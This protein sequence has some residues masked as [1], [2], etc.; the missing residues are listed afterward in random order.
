MTQEQSLIEK[1]RTLQ[2]SSLTCT[3]EVFNNT[4]AEW[5]ITIVAV[6]SRFTYQDSQGNVIGTSDDVKPNVAV[7][8]GQSVTTHSSNADECVRSVDTVIVVTAPD[9]PNPAAYEST[10]SGDAQSCIIYA[11][12]ILGPIPGET[13]VGLRKKSRVELLRLVHGQENS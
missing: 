7:T 8:S 6:G 13:A 11:P 10:A 1:V 2:K 5:G 4:P 9:E 12:M 3:V